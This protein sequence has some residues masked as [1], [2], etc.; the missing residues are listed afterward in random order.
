MRNLFS[1]LSSYQWNRLETGQKGLWTTVS[2]SLGTVPVVHLSTDVEVSTHPTVTLVTQPV[3]EPS[4]VT[5]PTG[6]GDFEDSVLETV[7]PLL[8]R[9]GCLNLLISN[10]SDHGCLFRRF[11]VKRTF[12]SF[13][14]DCVDLR[15]KM[16]TRVEWSYYSAWSTHIHASGGN[17]HYYRVKSPHVC[18]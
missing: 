9:V 14:R 13:G 12:G 7:A 8:P 2:F 15:Y 10:V 16:L 18:Y 17:A 1:F 6:T 3:G 4:R 11:F 5:K